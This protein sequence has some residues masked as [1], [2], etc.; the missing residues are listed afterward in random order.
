MADGFQAVNIEKR[1]DAL[2]PD[3]RLTIGATSDL[4][5]PTIDALRYYEAEGL[6]G[7]VERDSGGRRLYARPNLYA[8]LVVH[9]MREAGFGIADIRSLVAIKRPD[10]PPHERIA[11]ARTVLAELEGEIDRRQHALIRAREL[12]ATWSAQL[13]G[14]HPGRETQSEAVSPV[15]R[16]T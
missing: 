16:P 1:I 2:P 14:A 15:Q 13:D 6:I 7:E 11:A 9:A 10:S 3:A 8:I 5:G 12:L 4:L